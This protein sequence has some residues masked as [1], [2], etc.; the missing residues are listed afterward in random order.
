MILP[1]ADAATFLRALAN[2]VERNEVVIERHDM[3]PR[4]IL[5]SLLEPEPIA[6]DVMRVQRDEAQRERDEL[7][8]ELAATKKKL[9]GVMYGR[10]RK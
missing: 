1:A 9:Q 8:L 5:L 3:Q 6:L 2:L 7:R 4:G 10:R